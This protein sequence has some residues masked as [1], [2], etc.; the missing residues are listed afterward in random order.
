M[1]SSHVWQMLPPHPSLC[2][3]LCRESMSWSFVYLLTQCS[4]CFLLFKPF[5]FHWDIIPNV[6]CI[7]G[8]Y[9]SPL[10]Q[11]G[12]MYGRKADFLWFFILSQPLSWWPGHEAN[13]WQ[14]WRLHVPWHEAVLENSSY[15]WL[16]WFCCSIYT[17]L[18][19]NYGNI[20]PRSHW[21][22]SCPWNKHWAVSCKVWNKDM[23]QF[24]RMVCKN[25]HCQFCCSVNKS[26][27]FN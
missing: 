2:E 4:P 11:L 23:S 16:C 1:V 7:N 18:T 8:A 17:F 24:L 3:T 22:K 21:K 13:M 26:L 25:C 15:H 6:I 19:F 27:T 20:T 5:L 14:R 9:L 10:H 12:K